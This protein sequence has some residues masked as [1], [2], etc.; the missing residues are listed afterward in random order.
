[1]RTFEHLESRWLPC[2]P[3]DVLEIVNT[4][5]A[6]QYNEAADVNADGMVSPL[7][8]LL[9]IN[10]ANRR[11]MADVNPAVLH[12]APSGAGSI[13]FSPCG[14]DYAMTL[15][16]VSDATPVLR[17]GGDEFLP[18]A[19]REFGNF[20]AWDF[21]VFGRGRESLRIIGEFPGDELLT[22]IVG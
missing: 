7:D 12:P 8:A 1:M 14:N 18:I 13:V 9:A 5:N 10:E 17:V 22:L 15:L 16:A 19:T 3:I 2:T 11:S 21:Q 4:V 20:N 6:G